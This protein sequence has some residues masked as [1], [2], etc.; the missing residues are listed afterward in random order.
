M[1]SIQKSSYLVGKRKEVNIKLNQ[2]KMTVIKTSVFWMMVA[3]LAIS[4][5]TILVVDKQALD[6]AQTQTEDVASQYQQC[7][8]NFETIEPQLEQKIIQIVPKEWTE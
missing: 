8:S 4:L 3:Y 2:N 5:Y 7:L 1:G 6:K